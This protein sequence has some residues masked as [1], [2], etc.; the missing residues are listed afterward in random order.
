MFCISNKP[1]G[2]ADAAGPQTALWVASSYVILQICLFFIRY[3]MYKAQDSK[4]LYIKKSYPLNHIKEYEWNDGGRRRHRR[5]GRKEE[6]RASVME[7]TFPEHQQ[8]VVE[9]IA[10]VVRVE[11]EDTLSKRSNQK[12]C[13]GGGGWS[14]I[15]S[16]LLFTALAYERPQWEPPWN[17]SP[18]VGFRKYSSL[19]P[20][21]NRLPY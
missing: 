17:A 8:L 7:K 16:Y 6:Q 3:F 4:W 2:D 5:R 21:D 13:W 19:T 12:Q 11:A 1:A 10:A 20:E 14:W 9:E 15:A 18:G